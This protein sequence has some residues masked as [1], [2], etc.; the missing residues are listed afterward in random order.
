MA[1]S[2]K[3]SKVVTLFATFQTKT[4][5]PLQRK[6]RQKPLRIIF[7][8]CLRLIFF[9]ETHDTGSFL[10]PD[11]ALSIIGPKD[12]LLVIHLIFQVSAKEAIR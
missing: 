8:G 11:A 3:L 7:L 9:K 5:Q 4:T 2:F 6:R 12:F 10:A 1:K